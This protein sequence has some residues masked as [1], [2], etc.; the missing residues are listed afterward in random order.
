MNQIMNEEEFLQ[1]IIMDWPFFHRLDNE[2]KLIFDEL[3]TWSK[4]EA[5]LIDHKRE[6]IV[7]LAGPISA[8][9]A[10]VMWCAGRMHY[11]LMTEPDYLEMLDEL[12][13]WPDKPLHP[14]ETY[15]GASQWDRATKTWKKIGPFGPT[16][17]VPIHP[18]KRKDQP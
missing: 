4:G 9:H 8:L 1:Y 2:T 15:Y 6:I 7:H 18:S 13:G 12:H 3:V 11:H 14:G 10:H 5:Y 16:D 17:N